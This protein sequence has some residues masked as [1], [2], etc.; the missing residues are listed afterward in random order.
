MA[1]TTAP[2]AAMVATITAAS[3]VADDTSDGLSI[4][5]WRAEI[6]R[7]ELDL[8]ATTDADA[9][10]IPRMLLCDEKL[11]C[12]R[13]QAR[14]LHTCKVGFASNDLDDVLHFSDLDCAQTKAGKAFLGVPA[15]PTGL[16]LHSAAGHGARA[17][18]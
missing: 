3:P 15:I 16:G 6:R 7:Q 4:S 8:D 17:P 9:G 1:P 2:A 14:L 5:R 13:V 11:I 10:C 18:G 12:N